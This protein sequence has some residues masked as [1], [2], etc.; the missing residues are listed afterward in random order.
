M[1][2][3]RLDCLR[4]AW[5]FTESAFLPA[6]GYIDTLRGGPRRTDRLLMGAAGGLQ[7]ITKI[8][9]EQV[10]SE[11]PDVTRDEYENAR[12]LS[13]HTKGGYTLGLD[14]G[15]EDGRMGRGR[16]RG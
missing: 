10:E 5:R 15:F 7:L 13:I 14:F 6:N 4:F 3:V 11:L 12:V 1:R 16:Y 8:E 9:M 2:I